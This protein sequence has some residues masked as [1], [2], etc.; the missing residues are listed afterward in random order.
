MP[1]HTTLSCSRRPRLP[2]ISRA[3]AVVHINYDNCVQGV[4]AYAAPCT[5]CTIVHRRF[6]P[7]SPGGCAG[8]NNNDVRTSHQRNLLALEWTGGQYSVEESSRRLQGV[9]LTIFLSHDV[10]V[11]S[12]MGGIV[13]TCISH[14]RKKQSVVFI[15]VTFGIMGARDVRTAVLA[16]PSHQNARQ[17]NDNLTKSR[18]FSLISSHLLRPNICRSCTKCMYPGCGSRAPARTE[19]WLYTHTHTCSWPSFYRNA[20]HATTMTTNCRMVPT[21]APLWHIMTACL[22]PFF[23]FIFFT[24]TFRHHT[25]RDNM[26][27]LVPLLPFCE[28][29]ALVVWRARVCMCALRMAMWMCSWFSWPCTRPNTVRW[30][31]YAITPATAAMVHVCAV[32]R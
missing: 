28:V 8:A 24:N 19:P 32:S 12:A 10:S 1:R 27:T 6:I 9:V 14:E 25:H 16:C 30:R 17:G 23:L 4:R 5:R 3:H 7:L 11:P 26:R 21:G 29:S 15:S 22:C 2:T 13:Y 20:A 31:I 18:K